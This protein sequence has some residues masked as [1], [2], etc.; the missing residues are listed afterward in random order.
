MTMRIVSMFGAFLVVTSWLFTPTW[1]DDQAEAFL[2][3]GSNLHAMAHPHCGH[4]HGHHDCGAHAD[5][6]QEL[7]QAAQAEYEE[8]KSSLECAQRY[9]PMANW[10]FGLGFCL[11]ICWPIG[12]LCQKL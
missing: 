4:D 10:I 12:M 7:L 9:E 1:N 6:D 3:A 8:L 5:V 11:I 2:L